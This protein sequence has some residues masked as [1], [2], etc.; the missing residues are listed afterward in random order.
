M[1]KNIII[2]GVDVSG[3]KYFQ[4][5]ANTIYPKA[6][7]CGSTFNR[8]CEDDENC[9]YKQLKRLEIENETLKSQLDFAVQQKEVLEQEN[10]KLKE[11]YQEELTVNTQLQEWQ[12]EDLRQIAELKRELEQAN[13]WNKTLW[14]KLEKIKEI[15]ETALKANYCNNCDG[16][17]LPDCGDYECHTYALDKIMNIIE[18]AKDE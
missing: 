6:H 12:D 13:E 1:D 10:A 14:Q 15:A 17:G 11:K 7:Y 5:E 4:I 8:F 9:V 2:D 16:V 18:G 3:C